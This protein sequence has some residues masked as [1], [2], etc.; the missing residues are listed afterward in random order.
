MLSA[1]SSSPTVNRSGSV[2]PV[3]ESVLESDT[4]IRLKRKHHNLVT[5][6]CR[7]HPLAALIAG[8]SALVVIGSI[9]APSGEH[10]ASSTAPVESGTATLATPVPDL[11]ATLTRCFC[12]TLS[13]ERKATAP[14]NGGVPNITWPEYD[15]VIEC[16]QRT[17][18]VDKKQA[19][20]TWLHERMFG[21][22]QGA[23]DGRTACQVVGIP[24]YAGEPPPVDP[25]AMQQAR[26]WYCERLAGVTH[27][28]TAFPTIDP[29]HPEES[30]KAIAEWDDAEDSAFGSRAHISREA[31][32]AAIERANGELV[33][34]LFV[35]EG[36]TAVAESRAEMFER[37]RKAARRAICRTVHVSPWS[38]VIPPDGVLTQDTT[39]AFKEDPDGKAWIGGGNNADTLLKTELA[40]MHYPEGCASGAKLDDDAVVNAP[41]TDNEIAA[42]RTAFCQ[43]LRE[44]SGGDIPAV[45][46]NEIYQ[47]LT[48]EGHDR[49][50]TIM[51]QEF[52]KLLLNNNS[53]CSDSGSS[54]FGPHSP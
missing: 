19:E 11:G 45:R 31:A 40:V 10:H 21:A 25:E 1:E 50:V 28:L 37:A 42:A 18:N 52:A 54:S 53:L 9:I 39:D 15:R 44:N 8:V 12:D 20:E 46:A 22:L 5:N 49:A 48:G 24:V 6:L 13:S 36:A 16:V 33:A 29:A 34:G 17:G 14:Q 47:S 38:S 41:A 51:G 2:V 32:R 27:G 35:C 43:A 7:R 4:E 23:D 30:R 26:G 3:V